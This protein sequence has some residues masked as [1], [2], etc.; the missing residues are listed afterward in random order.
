M[1]DYAQVTTKAVGITETTIF[2]E[3]MPNGAT[4]MNVELTNTGGTAFTG[5]KVYR[6]ITPDAPWETV[7][8]DADAYSA[9]FEPIISVR[10]DGVAPFTLADAGTVNLDIDVA[11]TYE[12]KITAIAGTAT[13]VTGSLAVN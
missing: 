7:C 4:R 2:Q 9:P 12:W 13:T 6:K 5:L 8:N 11:S 1:K 3:K 10:P